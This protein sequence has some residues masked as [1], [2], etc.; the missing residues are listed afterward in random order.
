[1]CYPEVALAASGNVK[2]NALNTFW[3]LL[4][5]FMVFLMQA[6]FG[7]V[8]AGLIRAK[9][10]A[11]I[12]MKNMMDF[13]MASLGFFAFG[14]AIMFGGD[15]ALFGTTGWFLIGAKSPAGVDVP[16]YA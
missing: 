5:A 11:N 10:A 15:G 13:C 4:A 9:N 6:G 7:M 16:M 3:V 14:Y 12:L 2:V 8:E 1:M